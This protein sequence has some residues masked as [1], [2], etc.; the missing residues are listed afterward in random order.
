M[1]I[2]NELTPLAYELSKKVFEGELTFKEGQKQ[3]VGDNRI[4]SNSAADYINNF[5]CMIEGKRF[6]RTNNAYSIE[7][8]C[9]SIYNDYGSKGL[10]NALTALKLHIEYYED[11]QKVIMHK[12]RGIYEKYK[13][14]PLDTLDEQEQK[15]IIHEIK[16]QNKSRQE[17][18]DELISLKPS[19]PEEIIIKTKSYKR[20]NKTIAQIKFIRDF[21]CQICSTTIKKKDGTFYIEAAHIE[22]KHKK[23]RETPENILLLCPNHHKE[24]DFGDLKINKHDKEK[25]DFTLN[26]KEYS[27]SLRIN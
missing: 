20:D 7:Y 27:I 26:E 24:F 14:V 10:S 2:L 16:S 9:D 13:A 4:N 12:M 5:R 8:F 19:D 1:K 22:P 3:M 25:V 6:T 21:K 17:I 18:I 15:E 23:G 11:I